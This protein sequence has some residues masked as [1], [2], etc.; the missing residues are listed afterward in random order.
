MVNL[1]LL[2]LHLELELINQTPTE[3]FDLDF[4][5]PNETVTEGCVEG[6]AL[7]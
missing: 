7:T 2:H 4:I 6:D 3:I 5:F 1:N